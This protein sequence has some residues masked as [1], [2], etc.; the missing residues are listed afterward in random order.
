MLENRHSL[1]PLG[2][3]GLC[4]I[5]LPTLGLAFF[6][7]GCKYYELPSAVSHGKKT[8]NP[9]KPSQTNK[10]LEFSVVPS[11]EHH[12]VV[13]YI[14]CKLKVF[15]HFTC[16]GLCYLLSAKTTGFTAQAKVKMISPSK[17]SGGCLPGGQWGENS[18]FRA[19]ETFFL[20]LLAFDTQHEHGRYKPQ[21]KHH[22]FTMS[23]KAFSEHFPSCPQSHRDVH[24]ALSLSTQ[25]ACR[26]KTVLKPH[27]TWDFTCESSGEKSS[28]SNEIQ[29]S[30]SLTRLNKI[31]CVERQIQ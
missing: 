14:T 2:C 22:K 19:S 10:I 7:L 13:I 20:K 16:P 4:S 5:L 21:V 24:D 28:C 30:F 6:H 1:S 25:A 26:R 31:N 12:Y 8:K 15:S 3:N 17:E 29:P 23:F 9:T 27:L 18:I 11:K